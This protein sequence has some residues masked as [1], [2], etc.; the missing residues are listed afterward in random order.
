M[1][2]F[3]PPSRPRALQKSPSVD[4]IPRNTN[5]NLPRLLAEYKTLLRKN[6]TH[7][8]FLQYRDNQIKISRTSRNRVAYKRQDVTAWLFTYNCIL[9]FLLP[10]KLFYWIRE[11]EIYIPCIKRYQT[12]R[13]I[14]FKWKICLLKVEISYIHVRRVYVY[15]NIKKNIQDFRNVYSIMFTH[16]VNITCANQSW[17]R[18]TRETSMFYFKD[19]SRVSTMNVPHASV[20][21]L[22]STD[23][24]DLRREESYISLLNSVFSPSLSFRLTFWRKSTCGS[25]TIVFLC[26]SLR[27]CCV[28]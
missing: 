11:K 14:S 1:I 28:F 6:V 2:Q 3:L 7:V 4:R 22:Y 25:T 5:I 10:W 13:R 15:I 24:T 27:G 8:I 20:F 18:I 9:C 12:P 26:A 23:L 21:S 16:T 17:I 19:S